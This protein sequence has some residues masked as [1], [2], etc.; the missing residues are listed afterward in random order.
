MKMYTECGNLEENYKNMFWELEDVV[1]IHNY[2]DAINNKKQILEDLEASRLPNHFYME[3]K[4]MYE[5][6]LR[7]L[8][9]FCT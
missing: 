5:L 6:Y 2:Q 7:G 3:A 8:Y 1:G 9:E 4:E